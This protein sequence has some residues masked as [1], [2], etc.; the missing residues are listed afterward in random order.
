MSTIVK[1]ISGFSN[2]FTLL[3]VFRYIQ[4]IKYPRNEFQKG[5]D[6]F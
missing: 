3:L 4:D 1:H 5:N 2:I 6:I